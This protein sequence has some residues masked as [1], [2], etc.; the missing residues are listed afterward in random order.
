MGGL[1]QKNQYPRMAIFYEGASLTMADSLEKAAIYA[2]S[3]CETYWDD[4]LDGFPPLD[5][6]LLNIDK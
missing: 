2:F 6:A 4:K 5:D 3:S 1:L